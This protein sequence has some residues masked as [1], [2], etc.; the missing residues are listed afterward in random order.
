MEFRQTRFVLAGVRRAGGRL[1][2]TSCVLVLTQTCIKPDLAFNFFLLGEVL[3]ILQF[4][5]RF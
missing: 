4:C 1:N 2:K 3:Q 5:R